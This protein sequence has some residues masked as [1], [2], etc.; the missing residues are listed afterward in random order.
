MMMPWPL[1]KKQNKQLCECVLVV[2]VTVMM[3]IHML[4]V[5]NYSVHRLAVAYTVYHE[6]NIMQL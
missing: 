3:V 5:I 4:I 6:Y 1:L 2:E